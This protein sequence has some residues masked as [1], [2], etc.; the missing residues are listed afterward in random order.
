[1]PEQYRQEMFGFLQ[2]SLVKKE[3]IGKKVTGDGMIAITNWH[4]LSGV[5][6][7]EQELDISDPSRIIKNIARPGKSSGN[8]LNVLDS[9]REGE[10]LNFLK[11][12]DDLVV[13]NDEAHHI[14][15]VRRMGE[16]L[17]VEWQK[18]LTYISEL[19]K[20]KF[21]QIDFSATPYDQI[22]TEKIFFPHIVV[23]FKG[24]KLKGIY[25]SFKNKKN[26]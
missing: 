9:P 2:S 26:H 18:S 10:V 4:L 22:G 8:D 6:E 12:I 13:F 17:E 11:S 5:E 7:K 15:E 21:I 25:V 19:K 20:N 1:M 14:H 3:D 24:K 23:D 16:V